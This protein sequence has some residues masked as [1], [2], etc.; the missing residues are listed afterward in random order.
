MPL[1]HNQLYRLTIDTHGLSAGIY[2]VV[3]TCNPP[4]VPRQ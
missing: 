1:M 4:P 3:M 2:R